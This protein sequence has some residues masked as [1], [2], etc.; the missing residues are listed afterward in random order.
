MTPSS[1][2]GDI[3]SSADTKN[4][5]AYEF[6]SELIQ[7]IKNNH[8]TPQADNDITIDNLVQS[9]NSYYDLFNKL[10]IP[11]EVKDL[12]ENK[13]KLEKYLFSLN[14]AQLK[15]RD[16][17]SRKQVRAFRRIIDNAVLNAVQYWKSI[18][19]RGICDY[20]AGLTDQEAMDEYEKLYAGIMELV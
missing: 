15:K 16:D 4:K 5:K 20:I 13:M 11:R 14:L 1:A 2:K 6:L 12:L 9:L 17:Y 8:N 19:T 7:D 10:P 18:L 3:K